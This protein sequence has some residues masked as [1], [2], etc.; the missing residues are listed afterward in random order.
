MQLTKDTILRDLADI[1]TY[2]DDWKGLLY[3]AMHRACLRE[4]Y[5]LELAR[6]GIFPPDAP[7]VQEESHEGL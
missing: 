3:E 2:P 5:R 6:R 7:Q 1:E 4:M